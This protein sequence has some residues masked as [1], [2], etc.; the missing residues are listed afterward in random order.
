MGDA[1]RLKTEV[2]CKN[3]LITKQDIYVPFASED[4]VRMVCIL[5]GAPNTGDV[6]TPTG[7]S[8]SGLA[9]LL[10]HVDKEWFSQSWM[11]GVLRSSAKSQ[12]TK[13]QGHLVK[14]YDRNVPMIASC[15]RR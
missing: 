1:L 6:I 7:C 5:T 2:P 13:V 4:V 15:V 12:G 3:A 9:R 11:Q 8:A 10:A 14:A